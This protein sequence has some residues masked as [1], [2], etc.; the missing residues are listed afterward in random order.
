MSNSQI[1]ENPVVPDGYVMVEVT[2]DASGKQKQKIIRGGKSKCSADEESFLKDLF[3]IEIE[4]YASPEEE[5]KGLTEEHAQQAE[6]GRVKPS[7][8]TP[9]PSTKKPFKMQPPPKKK[10]PFMEV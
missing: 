2:T 1:S 6:E 10:T 9:P 4:G 5:S 8:V 7:L 3:S